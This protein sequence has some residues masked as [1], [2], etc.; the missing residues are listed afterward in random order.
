M[1]DNLPT[2]A[3]PPAPTPDTPPAAPQPPSTPAHDVTA[4]PAPAPAQAAPTL[5]D[6]RQAVIDAE[7]N[8]QA[9]LAAMDAAR[10][11]F[12][13]GVMLGVN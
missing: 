12:D 6:L 4:A 10:T 8:F 9:A 3:A 1:P 5:S 13:R 2:Q 11:A 7:A